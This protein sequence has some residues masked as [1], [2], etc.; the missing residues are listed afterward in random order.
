VV[1]VADPDDEAVVLKLKAAADAAD[2]GLD[3]A[4]A[5]INPR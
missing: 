5:G 3:G 1:V 2:A 4:E